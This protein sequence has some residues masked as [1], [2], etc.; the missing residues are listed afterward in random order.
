[1][2]EEA[3]VMSAETLRQTLA[4]AEFSLIFLVRKDTSVEATTKYRPPGVRD[5]VLAAGEIRVRAD[6]Q[7]IP[8]IDEFS[9]GNMIETLRSLKRRLVSL[10]RDPELERCIQSGGWCEWMQRYWN[11]LDADRLAREDEPVYECLI[12]S[13][14][15]DGKRGCIASY[16]YQGTGL[17]EACVRGDRGT[18]GFGLRT[19]VNPKATAEVIQAISDEISK[20]VRSWL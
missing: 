16:Q 13:M 14:I 20:A 2:A 19:T 1:L 10:E 18:T 11:R 5:F 3:A 8:L 12:R 17:I 4:F 6:E 15:V 9:C 7:E